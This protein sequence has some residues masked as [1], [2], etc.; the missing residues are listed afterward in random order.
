M[1]VPDLSN[2]TEVPVT[3]QIDV[4]AELN[5]MDSPAF[6]DTVGTKGEAVSA[7]LDIVGKVIV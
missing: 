4:V 7:R 3:W 1:H 5:V 6:E 2:A